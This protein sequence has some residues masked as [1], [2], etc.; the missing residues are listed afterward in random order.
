MPELTS[1]QAGGLPILSYS[2]E[3]STDFVGSGRRLATWT[4]L[5]GY[6]SDYP[7]SYYTFSGLTTGDAIH[8]RYLVKNDAGWSG[9]SPEMLT[10]VGT[11][12]AQMVAP[13]TVI[14]T[15]PLFILV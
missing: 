5:V 4:S 11:K 12:P 7:L 9:E 8:F 2:L 15:D 3:Y 10:Y 1:L 14:E 13:T 6:D